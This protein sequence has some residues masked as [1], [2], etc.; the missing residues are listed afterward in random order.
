MTP[1]VRD[2]PAVE[3]EFSG[4]GV[5][6]LR[7]TG[8]VMPVRIGDGFGVGTVAPDEGEGCTPPGLVLCDIAVPLV[9]CP[10]AVMARLACEPVLI[11]SVASLTLVGTLF[12]RMAPLLPVPLGAPLGVMSWLAGKP[13]WALELELSDPD[14]P[15]S[16]ENGGV[17]EVVQ[18]EGKGLSGEIIDA[19]VDRLAIPL[20]AAKEAR[21]PGTSGILPGFKNSDGRR[22]RGGLATPGFRIFGSLSLLGLGGPKGPPPCE[23]N[24]PT[25]RP[26]LS[27]DESLPLPFRLPLPPAAPPIPIDKPPGLEG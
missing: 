6:L 11:R 17:L 19:E 25:L 14:P 4:N 16:A 13:A 23:P 26:L 10:E 22:C 12:S 5:D 20:L 8:V 9:A 2:S 15:E 27:A 18:G 3:P 7:S 24:E 1:N 21:E